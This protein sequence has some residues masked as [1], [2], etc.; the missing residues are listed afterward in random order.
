MEVN[1]F[2][3]ENSQL[4]SVQ[5]CP[6]IASVH[7][8]PKDDTDED[9][10]RWF[11]Y[12]YKMP[13]VVRIGL[14]DQRIRQAVLNISKRYNLMNIYAVGEISRI[15]RDI[16]V[17]G[18]REV[19]VR[20]RLE[21]RLKLR[22]TDAEHFIVDLKVLVSLVLKVG[23][24]EVE[25]EVDWLPI[26]KALE[27]Y[28]KLGSQ[29]ISDR[30]IVLKNFT[31]PVVGNIKNWL[32]DYFSKVGTGAH[33]AIQRSEFLFNSENARNLTIEQR[34]RLSLILRSYDT[35]EN[36]AIKKEEQEVVFEECANADEISSLPAKKSVSPIPSVSNAVASRVFPETASVSRYK[37]NEIAE[38]KSKFITK[39]TDDLS[40]QRISQAALRWKQLDKKEEKKDRPV[41]KNVVDLSEYI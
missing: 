34:N 28:E 12:F 25:K 3:I 33:G 18:I 20:Q 29:L 31:Q 1:N 15:L 2:P 38:N 36:L 5:A 17:F 22:G 23:Q 26:M 24:E 10:T 6:M 14:A 32:E 13:M 19:E 4:L 37:S 8:N 35:G 9:F 11:G 41:G 16:Y 30:N 27:K 39:D 21:E 40:S 7:W